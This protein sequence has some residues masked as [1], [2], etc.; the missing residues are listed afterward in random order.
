M[1]TRV[2]ARRSPNSMSRGTVEGCFLGSRTERRAMLI[3]SQIAH[4]SRSESTSLQYT[5]YT[6]TGGAITSHSVQSVHSGRILRATAYNAIARRLYAIARPSVCLSVCPSVCPS[7]TRVIQ[8]KTVEVRIMQLSVFH[9][10][11]AP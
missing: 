4:R 9:H 2:K 5:T 10:Q 6:T 8:S 7:V 3:R 1:A 11:V